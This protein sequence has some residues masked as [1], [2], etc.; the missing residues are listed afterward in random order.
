MCSVTIL[1][2]DS[3]HKHAQRFA[4]I[5][6][7]FYASVQVGKSHTLCESV[8]THSLRTHLCVHTVDKRGP[9]SIFYLL[10]DLGGLSLA[11]LKS[12][13]VHADFKTDFGC[14]SI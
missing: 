10:T 14:G 11:L 7:Y 1:L 8:L 5:Y 13:T 9:W 6:T 2:L 3:L 4:Y 12:F